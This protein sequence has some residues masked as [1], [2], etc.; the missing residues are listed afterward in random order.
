VAVVTQGTSHSLRGLANGTVLYWTVVPNDG[1]INGTPPQAW[2][3]HV[4]AIAPPPPDNRSPRFTS[5][6]PTEATV[7]ALLEYKVTA[8]D[9]DGDVLEYSLPMGPAGAAIDTATGRLAWTPEAYQLG[10]QNLVVTVRDG[11]GAAASQHFTITVREPIWRGPTCSVDTRRLVAR[12]GEPIT[13]SGTAIG[14]SAEVVY[15]MLR[16]DGGPWFFAD[17]RL[18]WSVVLDSG[19]YSPGTHQ[20]EARAFDGTALSDPALAELVVEKPETIEGTSIL[21]ALV[22]IVGVVLVL[23]AAMRVLRARSKTR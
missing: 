5:A 1:K 14:G 7:G 23:V 20:V 18:N 17:G 12:Q 4:E 19:R 13:F 11:R 10:E 16:V 3:F 2:H 15:V 22:V 8:T 9:E 6:P 21:W